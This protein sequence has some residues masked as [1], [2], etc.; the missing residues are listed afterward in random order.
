MFTQEQIN[1]LQSLFQTNNET[2]KKM[3][4][5]EVEF[6]SQKIRDNLRLE[7]HHLEVRLDELEDEL[8]D[9]KISNGRLEREIKLLKQGQEELKTE[10]FV[11]TKTLNYIKKKLNKTAK[12]V[13]VIGRMFDSD[14]LEN[15]KR[16]DRIENIFGI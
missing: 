2:I 4:R 6:E 16:I 7:M 12:T 15:R 13:D 10:I 9:L 14:I 1:Q 3:V 5:E 11:H 8:K